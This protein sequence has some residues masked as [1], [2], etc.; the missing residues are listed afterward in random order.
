MIYKIK[1]LKALFVL[2]SFC[3]CHCPN[4]CSLKGICV[5]DENLAGVCFCNDHFDTASAKDCSQRQCPKGS[6]WSDFAVE[7]DIAHELTECS[8][9]GSCD[10]STGSCLCD[11][12]FEGISCN[13]MTCPNDCNDQGRCVSISERA[14]ELGFKYDLWDSNMIYGCLCST[15]YSGYD[16]SLISCPTR[17]VDPSNSLDEVQIIECVCDD[18]EGSVILNLPNGYVKFFPQDDTNTILG[19]IL[20]LPNISG[21]EV[22]LVGGTTFCD[23]DGVNTKLIFTHNPGSVSA[24]TIIKNSLSTSSLTA[25][26][27]NVY[28]KGSSTSLLNEMSVEGMGETRTCTGRGECIYETGECTCLA[29][30]GASDGANQPVS[31]YIIDCSFQKSVTANCPFGTNDEGS[32]EV[33][34]GHGTCDSN[35]FCNC[36][37]GYTGLACDRTSCPMG[38][39][40]FD[41]V[42]EDNIA[43]AI[44]ECS[45]RGFCNSITGECS[46][47]TGFSG[48]A[49]EK[50]NCPG[51]NECSNQGTCFSTGEL[52]LL[53]ETSFGELRGLSYNGW[54]KSSTQ[55]CYCDRDFYFGPF[56]HSRAKFSG[57]DC[58][59][60][61]CSFGHD[62]DILG[63][64][65]EIQKLTCSAT[66][67]NFTL[68]FAGKLSTTIFHSDS[69]NI[70]QM[71][72][73]H[74]SVIPGQVILAYESSPTTDEV[75]DG[76]PIIIRFKLAGDAPL[77]K[78]NIEYLSGTVEFE[79]VQKGTTDQFE[80]SGQGIC[81]TRTGNCDCFSGRMSGDGSFDGTTPGEFGDCS[82]L[83]MF[84]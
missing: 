65:N 8:N 37:Q 33:C 61:S 56:A 78:A 16:C 11:D 23:A 7:V 49:C 52:A 58:S 48:T 53:S 41:D 72:V 45:N 19:K 51:E 68:S 29:E 35:L 36:A 60:Y 10:R 69:L 40:W 27:I 3:S 22:E 47:Q 77:F 76:T 30:Y 59:Q 5:Y 64:V 70:L 4:D 82:A 24:I 66:S 71:Q 62:T 75:C 80:C 25:P 84:G 54:D 9:R 81:D 31:G 15:G 46:C 2:L 38:L 6:A 55:G 39:A 13:R 42:T 26:M 67:G 18:C 34:A 44:A 28:T 32:N 73:D 79:E 21:I 1:L 20:A 57:H 74:L 50:L 12:G 14:S 17:L 83:M 63:K 43:H